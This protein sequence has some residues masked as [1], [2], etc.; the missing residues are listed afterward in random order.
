MA[1]YVALSWGHKSLPHAPVE[2]GD[3]GRIFTTTDLRIRGDIV[4]W[5]EHWAHGAQDC[6]LLTRGGFTYWD[7]MFYGQMM[8]ITNR[9]RY[10]KD[11][12]GSW[13]ATMAQWPRDA[14]ERANGMRFTPGGVVQPEPRQVLD[15][16]KMQS[17][18]GRPLQLRR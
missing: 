1:V 12:M 5:V 11:R 17:T 3:V 4:T 10:S 16:S 18:G 15:T 6:W 2:S 9:Q 7:G 8:I 13:F 14:L